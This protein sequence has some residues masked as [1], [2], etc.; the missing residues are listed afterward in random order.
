MNV[1]VS[2]VGSLLDKDMNFKLPVEVALDRIKAGITSVVDESFP[3]SRTV[4]VYVDNVKVCIVK[5]NVSYETEW[6]GVL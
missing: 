6:L 4:T 3:A 1:K 2:I 5:K